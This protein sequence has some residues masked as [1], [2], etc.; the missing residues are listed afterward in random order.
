MFE[1]MGDGGYGVYLVRPALP[2]FFPFLSTSTEA[3]NAHAQFFSSMMVLSIPFLVFL[4]PE[5]KNVPLEEMVRL[6]SPYSRRPPRPFRS[7]RLCR[8]PSPR[9]TN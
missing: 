3:R 7:R 8:R 9:H 2:L 1:Q 6:A 4:L 5:T